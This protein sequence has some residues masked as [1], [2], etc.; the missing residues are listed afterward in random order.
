MMRWLSIP[1]SLSA[2]S[3]RTPKMA[4]VDPVMPMMRRRITILALQSR[5]PKRTSPR[6][7]KGYQQMVD[8]A[9]IASGR[10]ALSAES[11]LEQMAE[12]LLREPALLRAG[13]AHL[14][15]LVAPVP[16]AA[17]VDD[18]AAV[19]EVAGR[20]ALGL[21]ARI[22]RGRQRIVDD[23]DRGGRIGARQHRPDQ[24]LEVRHVDVLVGDDDVAPRIG[25]R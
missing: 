3:I 23:V 2:S 9:T 22:E 25:A 5:E 13:R 19:G 4:P 18:G 14:R 20:L 16:G 8:L 15:K 11:A 12:P 1:L 24:L 17:G 10:P 21:D 7:R 6:F